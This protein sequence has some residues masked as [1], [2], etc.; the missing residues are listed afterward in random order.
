MGFWGSYKTRMEDQME[1]SMDNYDMISAY[2]L[3]CHGKSTGK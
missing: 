2:G 1:K 3:M